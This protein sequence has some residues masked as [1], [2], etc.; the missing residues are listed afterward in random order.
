MNESDPYCSV[1]LYETRK[2]VA[3]QPH[4]HA[5]LT[6]REL[7]VDAL[8]LPSHLERGRETVCLHLSDSSMSF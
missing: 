2:Y 5:S 6:E 7:H 3:A 1:I 4:H 8:L